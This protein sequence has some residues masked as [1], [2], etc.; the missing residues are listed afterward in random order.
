MLPEERFIQ[1][2]NGIKANRFTKVYGLGLMR[3]LMERRRPARTQPI[4]VRQEAAFA[5]RLRKAGYAV[6][7]KEE[8]YSRE[9]EK[10]EA[11]RR[12]K[13][14]ERARNARAHR[15]KQVIARR[16]SSGSAKSPVS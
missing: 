9:I 11:K 2:K 16:E 14:A 3:S 10:L 4:A 12:E 5:R 8:A 13:Q 1:H 15:R 7:P 6:W